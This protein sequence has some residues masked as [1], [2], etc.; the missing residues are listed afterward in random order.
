ALESA[1]MPLV[2]GAVSRR[3]DLIDLIDGLDQKLAKFQRPLQAGEESEPAA[4]AGEDDL[5]RVT[6]DL[7]GTLKM[8]Q[9][10]DLECA[11]LA[12]QGYQS[13]AGEIDRSAQ[14][15]K[16]LRGYSPSQDSGV[17]RFVSYQ[18]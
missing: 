2:E 8:I 12:E 11:A 6:A 18:T 4:G 14:E 5:A 3:K 15:Q 1:D 17:P 7:N 13:L 10:I 16:G 9:E